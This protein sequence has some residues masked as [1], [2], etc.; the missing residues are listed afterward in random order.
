MI[1]SKIVWQPYHLQLH[2]GLQE[3]VMIKLWAIQNCADEKEKKEEEHKYV[4]TKNGITSTLSASNHDEQSRAPNILE[5]G[6]S[7]SITGDERVDVEAQSLSS[8][9]G[10]PPKFSNMHPNSNQQENNPKLQVIY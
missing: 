5:E 9:R 4:Y 1:S 8:K 3:N 6:V 2:V 10:V 7:T